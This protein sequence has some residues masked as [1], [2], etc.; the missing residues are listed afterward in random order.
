MSSSPIEGVD[1]SRYQ[2]DVDFD[3]ARK[4]ASFAYL[5]ATEGDSYTDPT[6]YRN[7]ARGA[8]NALWVG[9]YHFFRPDIDPIKQAEHF[10]AVA[11][12]CT[13]LRPAI[14][15]ETLR[16]VSK[17]TACARCERFAMRTRELWHCEPII[18]SYPSFL[19][20][21]S[22]YVRGLADLDLWI[23]HYT[24]GPPRIP[25]PWE[26]ALMHQYDGDG[27]RTL[28]SGT[29]CDFNRTPD[30]KRLMRTAESLLQ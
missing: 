21:L 6:F 12:D 28:P 29:D 10:A 5:K 15:F 16:A 9:A 18:Y 30:L 2:G 11:E 27:G 3:D 17:D 1:F 4:V 7:A 24:T 8:H 19:A 26:S 23:A 14:D 22:P 13:G 20:P 25:G